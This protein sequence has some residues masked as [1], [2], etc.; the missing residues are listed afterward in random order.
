MRWLSLT[1]DFLSLSHT[2]S[3]SLLRILILPLLSLSHDPSQSFSPPPLSLLLSHTHCRASLSHCLSHSFSPLHSAPSMSLTDLLIKRL[4]LPRSLSLLLILLLSPPRY[5]LACD[6][7]LSLLTGFSL[8]C[9]SLVLSVLTHTLAVSLTAAC[10][11]SLSP[12]CLVFSHTR[13]LACSCTPS[14]S[15]IHSLVLTPSLSLSLTLVV[16]PL[17]VVSL[18]RT[19]SL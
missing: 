17:L 9:R 3:L 2:L 13:S 18:T 6:G 11:L 14:L 7:P 1:L 4:P 10:S 19:L 5:P 16:S 12:H 8:T 15:L